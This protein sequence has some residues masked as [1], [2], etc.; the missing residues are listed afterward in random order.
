MEAFEVDI[1]AILLCI[2][3]IS[4]FFVARFKLNAAA[5][6]LFTLCA[7]TLFL[8]FTGM[9]GLLGYAVW[10]VYAFALFCPVYL[11]AIKKESVKKVAQ[12]LFKPG[13]VFFIAATVMFAVMFA[14]RQPAFRK[15]DEFTFWGPAAKITVTAR[16]LYTLVES[17]IISTSYPPFLAVLSF[18]V[19]SLSIGFTEWKV[20]LAYDMLLMACMA[21]IFANI[22]WK[23][24]LSIAAAVA[25]SLLGLYFFK[26]SFEQNILYCSVYS[27]IPLGALFGGALLMHFHCEADGWPKFLATAS[28]IASLP[29][30][31]D[32]GMALG[33]IAAG[34]IF[35]D[36]ALTGERPTKRV[37]KRESR[38]LSMVYPLLLIVLARANHLIWNA[39]FTATSGLRRA[40]VSY[41]YSVFEILA[42]KDPF[43]NDLFKEMNDMLFTYQIDAFAC[44][45][46]TVILLTLLPIA[47]SLF[48]G[49]GKR[50]ARVA[51]Y[52]LVMCAGF[53]AYYYFHTYCYTAVFARSARLTSFDRYISTYLIGWMI[54]DV[55]VILC[56]CGLKYRYFENAGG[57]AACLLIVGLHFG[58]CPSEPAGYIFFGSSIDIG[59]SAVRQLIEEKVK[60]F[61]GLTPDDRI[62]FVCQGSNGGEAFVFNYE[63][64]PAYTV[65]MMGGGNF[66]KP[67][68]EHDGLY[69]IEVDRQ[70]FADYLIEQ[71]VDL[72]FMLRID[73]Y[74]AEE[75]M[76]LFWDNLVY[77]FNGSTDA[78]YVSHDGSGGVILIPVESAA[79]LNEL[80]ANA[81]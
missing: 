51:A 2:V 22:E 8:I 38:V 47:A 80:R 13:M 6:P 7:V 4:M 77:Y 27:D 9:A 37:F 49:S 20:Y 41:E 56:C 10:A 55:G 61:D 59:K 72:V 31:K 64:M 57:I 36:M 25:F 48:T 34:V 62:Y 74:F 73:D 1:A 75:C 16:Q 19:Q 33:M 53:F 63:M 69:D 5:A 68:S 71:D 12:E 67:G 28:A 54:A 70:D 43:F 81:G 44:F 78:Y 58:L 14:I 66:V 40:V 18:F 3:F 21:L 29:M 45:G 50:I 46:V 35:V 52:A 11:F 26:N 65:E 39:H 76:P 15:W 32:V 24:V 42:G 60:A 79:R 23:H 30:L 17:S